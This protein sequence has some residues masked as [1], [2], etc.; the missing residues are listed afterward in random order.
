MESWATCAKSLAPMPNKG[1]FSPPPPRLLVPLLLLLPPGVGVG[2]LPVL[3]AACCA[4]S[5]VSAAIMC[6][7]F[8]LVGCACAR[9]SSC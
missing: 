1:P 8:G 5:R 2:G 6:G 4:A 9:F 7:L 3:R